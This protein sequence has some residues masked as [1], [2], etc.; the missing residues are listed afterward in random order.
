VRRHF[1]FPAT[2]EG[3][4][5]AGA[6][7]ELPLFALVH[8]QV[9]VDGVERL[10]EP[11][12]LDSRAVPLVLCESYRPGQSLQV[13]IHAYQGDGF[14]I[15]LVQ[16]VEISSLEQV[17]FDLQVLANQMTFA[18]LL[19]FD[20]GRADP[21]WQALWQ[22]AAEALDLSALAENDWDAWR[23]STEA[24]LAILAPLAETAKTYRT[25]L[26][27]HS[28][29]DMNWLWPWRE[30]VD[31]IRRDFEAMDGLMERYPDF[32]F[33]QSQA[34]T[35][36]TMEQ[37]Q[38]ELLE[39]V[40]RRVSEGRWEVSASTWVEGDLNMQSGESLVRHLLLSRPYTQNTLGTR[41]RICWEPDT[42]GHCATLPQLLQ[43]AGVDYYYFCRAGQG[44]P[45][46]WWQGLDGSRV[47]AFNDFLGYNGAVTPDSVALPAL[48]LAQ[49]HG[50]KRGLYLYGVGDHGGGATARDIEK[51]RLLDATPLLP[52]ATM[53]DLTSFYDGV[54]DAGAELPVIAGELNTTFEGCYTTHADI[55]MSFRT[56]ENNLLSTESLATL[57]LLNS[58]AAYPAERLTDA[59]RTLL[60]HSFHDILCGCAI[61]ITYRE[62]A[63]ELAKVQDTLHEIGAHALD[64]LAA[65]VDSQAK[66]GPVVT[67]WNP[68]GWERTDLVRVAQKSLDDAVSALVDDRGAVVPV[69]RVG[70]ELLFVAR[71]VPAL[72]CRVFRPC[73]DAASS[74]LLVSNDGTCSNGLLRFHVHPHSGAIDSLYDCANG[75]A[76]D[77]M[78]AGHGVER[79]VNAGLINRLQVL[80]EEP[81]PMSAWNIGDITRTESLISGA[82]VAV[83]EKGPVRI[84]VEVQHAFLHSYITQRYCLYDG[85]PY[86]D[87]ETELDWHER[88]GKDSDAPML[89]ALFKPQLSAARATFEI[90]FAGLRRTATGD[91]VPALRWADMSDGAYGLSVLNNGKYGHQAHGTTL[92][93]TLCRAPYEP[94]TLPDQGLQQFSYALYP[95]AGDWRAAATERQAAGY[96]QPLCA[97]PTA[98]TTLN[99]PIA[100]GRPLMACEPGNVMI[101]ALKQAQEP[102]DG[103][104]AVIVRLVEMHGRSAEA[105]LTW[106]WQVT[107]VEQT[108]IL[109]EHLVDIPCDGASCRL[110]MGPHQVVTV[111][112]WL[113]S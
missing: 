29:I 70:Q 33:S 81:H 35:Y 24:A 88:G 30:T 83:T 80:W 97:V 98:A 72:G 102:G 23:R 47:L 32:H 95:H 75:R 41:T 90:P 20:S 51:A 27:G 57:A 105:R 91:E 26:V 8:S 113:G 74:S 82:E 109:E 63:E 93:L 34:A 12:W 60:L 46:F 43:Q 69:Q 103:G 19:S 17:V 108:N 56:C 10:A 31:V 6:R 64:A 21:G 9:F 89:R 49:R 50:L 7:V 85:L 67:V 73:Q 25:H 71:D 40:Q 59:W 94:D 87:V 86:I 52:R 68:L 78:S 79:K 22:Q 37:Q 3:I 54:R 106:G 104:D 55:K 5:T 13:T 28:H 92:G 110:S 84:V 36:L 45:L 66:S 107:R 96:N 61:G 14:G 111:R 77:T 39:R 1:Q 38:P 99:G 2:I 48:E 76:V 101:T 112:L 44:Q 15:C 100:P 16:H 53:S 65:Q 42:F 62:A 18:H 4:P 11:S 58:G